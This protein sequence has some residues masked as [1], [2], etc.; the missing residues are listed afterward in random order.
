MPGIRA[1]GR[2]GA[3]LPTGVWGSSGS[4]SQCRGASAVVRAAGECRAAGA[5]AA[6]TAE[7]PAVVWK[8]QVWEEL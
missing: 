6:M 1:V 4:G 2:A 8:E 7:T 3:S 5:G